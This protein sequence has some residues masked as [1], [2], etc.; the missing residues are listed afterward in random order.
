MTK[1]GTKDIFS[2]SERVGITTV[3]LIFMPLE[4][5]NHIF[6]ALLS[7]SLRFVYLGLYICIHGG[8]IVGRIPIELP[9]NFAHL[10]FANLRA[11]F[12]LL[13]DGKYFYKIGQFRIYAKKGRW[14][15]YKQL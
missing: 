3:T 14:I 15:V 8:G 7:T 10:H 13:R 11:I 5:L 1:L 4:V 9:P 6:V 2:S 12:I